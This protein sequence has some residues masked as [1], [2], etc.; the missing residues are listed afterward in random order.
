MDTCEGNNDSDFSPP[1]M[2]LI[3]YLA[4]DGTHHPCEAWEHRALAVRIT[5][6]EQPSL[7]DV[8]D[9]GTMPPCAEQVLDRGCYVRIHREDRSD[10]MCVTFGASFYDDTAAL[11]DA[12]KSWLLLHGYGRWIRHLGAR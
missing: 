7:E 1:P 11:T 4:P 5:G 2:R 6:I 9:D 3:G 12:Q 8:R 10:P